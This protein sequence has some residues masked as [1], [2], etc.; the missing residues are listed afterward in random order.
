MHITELLIYLLLL[1]VFLLNI[2]S[3]NNV[4]NVL[5]HNV[6][7]TNCIFTNSCIHVENFINSFQCFNCTGIAVLFIWK[8]Y[9]SY[10]FTHQ[11]ILI[12]CE[13]VL[14]TKINFDFQL[15]TQNH[16]IIFRTTELCLRWKIPFMEV[17]RMQQSEQRMQY[18]ALS[19]R[20]KNLVYVLKTYCIQY[21][22]KE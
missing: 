22:I 12:F 14:L 21:F 15:L 5:S 18:C 4:L 3:L 1:Q 17:Q 19:S 6:Y 11:N 20:Q 9:Y 16:S 7:E 8:N 10:S 13:V 2:L